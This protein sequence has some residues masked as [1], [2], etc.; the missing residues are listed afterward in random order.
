MKLVGSFS[1]LRY[2]E[3]LNA[4]KNPVC[5]SGAG[6]IDLFLYTYFDKCLSH[7]LYLNKI[8]SAAATWQPHVFDAFAASGENQKWYSNRIAIYNI[9]NLW[10]E[11]REKHSFVHSEMYYM[12]ILK[13]TVN[14]SR[15]N[16][17]WCLNDFGFES[18]MPSY[19]NT[20]VYNEKYLAFW[21]WTY[22]KIFIANENSDLK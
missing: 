16:C 11:N 14:G 8:V 6:L 2:F 3:N 4:S 1:F 5:H 22:K 17:I 21:S 15:H 13:T 20:S 7:V 10:R 9:L 19:V 12:I 18:D